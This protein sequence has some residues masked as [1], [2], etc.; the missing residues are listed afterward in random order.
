MHAYV[1]I[2][3][4]RFVRLSCLREKSFRWSHKNNK[5]NL[6]KE[7]KNIKQFSFKNHSSHE[8]SVHLGVCL[9]VSAC[10]REFCFLLSFFL[11][12][13][14]LFPRSD[15]FSGR[16][17]IPEERLWQ[18]V[19][20]R[21]GV[22]FGGETL[23]NVP[24][25][26]YSVWVFW[27]CFVWKKKKKRKTK[28]KCETLIGSG[29]SFFFFIEQSIVRIEM[30]VSKFDERYKIKFYRFCC[31]NFPCFFFIYV[32]IYIYFCFSISTEVIVFV[33]M[34][35]ESVLC[36]QSL[37]W[38]TSRVTACIVYRVWAPSLAERLIGRY[39]FESGVLAGLRYLGRL[40]RSSQLTY[41]E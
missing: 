13:F 12:F 31:C 16:E 30:S 8:T 41:S 21:R 9:C 4:A 1:H 38:E 2:Y 29:I 6:K 34:F 20:K 14:F 23:D 37:V 15:L 35:G 28:R 25:H 22:C 11:K 32:C 3:I 18:L 39:T 26:Y 19:T 7:S 27:L 36:N 40:F 17:C 24:E 10:V 33:W 5:K